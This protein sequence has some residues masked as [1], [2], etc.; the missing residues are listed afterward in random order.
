MKQRIFSVLSWIIGLLALFI[1]IYRI[2]QTFSESEFQSALN[3]IFERSHIFNLVITTILM[4]MNWG[5]ESWK[6]FKISAC[7]EKKSFG[8]SIMAVLAGLAYGHLLPGRSSEFMGKILFYSD[9]NKTN[10]SILHFINAAFQMYITLITGLLSV[11]FY[12]NILQNT[13]IIVILLI[14]ILL[15]IIL[16][17]I[18]TYANKLYFLKR[19]FPSLEYQIPMKLKRELVV[20]SLIRYCI[21]ILQFYF[22]FLVFKPEQGLNLQF[23]SSLAIYFL[24]TSIIPMISIIE[25]AIRTLIGILVFHPLGI[26]EME[27]SIITT[28]MWFIN[29]ALPG[30]IGFILWFYFKKTKWK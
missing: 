15:I 7:V 14:C 3:I 19:I 16:T 2:E 11:F 30:M 26:K 1:F 12:L 23:I 28:L 13:Y 29:L 27:I 22:I 21:F 25:V 9:K 20:W 8:E 17:L 5:I 18:I 24:F 6:W 4:M 10:I